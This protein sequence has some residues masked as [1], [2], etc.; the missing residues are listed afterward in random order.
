MMTNIKPISN[1]R[2]Y[3]LVLSE[4]RENSPVY[5]TSNGRGVCAII[6]LEEL[7]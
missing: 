7:D 2:N 4:V 6:K 3:T 1:L 5:L